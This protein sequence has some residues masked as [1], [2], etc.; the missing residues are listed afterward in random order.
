ELGWKNKGAI[1][2]EDLALEKKE[3][4]AKEEK[5][6]DI[7]KKLF[8]ENKE[9]NQF[10]LDYINYRIT[11]SDANRVYLLKHHKEAYENLKFIMS[12]EPNVKR[13]IERLVEGARNSNNYKVYLTQYFIKENKYKKSE[14]LQDTE[15]KEKL[16]FELL[17]LKEDNKSFSKIRKIIANNIPTFTP[18]HKITPNSDVEKIL[19]AIGLKVKFV[20]NKVEILKK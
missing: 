4:K 20:V 19:K 14:L 11:K 12:I 5:P 16:I 9:V 17:E 18:S 15:T 7:L 13:A 3:K 1:L 2:I 10:A 6:K 8:I